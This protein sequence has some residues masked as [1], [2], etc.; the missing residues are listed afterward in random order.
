MYKLA[1]I[2]KFCTLTLI[3]FAFTALVVTAPVSAQGGLEGNHTIRLNLESDGK[4]QVVHKIELINNTT[5]VIQA[6][7]LSLPFTK[8]KD[9]KV[10]RGSE[11]IS[12]RVLPGGF[13]RV[14]L[15]NKPLFPQRKATLQFEYQLDNQL[16]NENGLL[17]FYLP[18]FRPGEKLA[19]YSAIIRYP[20]NFPA[21]SYISDP[22][23]ITD[24][25]NKL[26]FSKNTHVKL[27]WGTEWG[28]ALTGDTSDV[29][30]NDTA[31]PKLINLIPDLPGQEAIY[32]NLTAEEIYYEQNGNV[33]ANAANPF[34]FDVA[35]TRNP[36]L[37]DQNT[38]L[39]YYE[40][41]NYPIPEDIMEKTQGTG[42]K[43]EKLEIVYNY[44]VNNARV[45]FE[46]LESTDQLLNLEERVSLLSQNKFNSLEIAYIFSGYLSNLDIEH[47]IDYGYFYGVNWPEFN[48]QMPHVWVEV[49]IDGETLVYDPFLDKAT[50][51]SFAGVSD[52]GRVRFGIWDPTQT[53][54]VLLGLAGPGIRLRPEVADDVVIASSSDTQLGVHPITL[55]IEAP[56]SMN[57]I[58]QYTVTVKL[59]N[60]TTTIIPLAQIFWDDIDFSDAAL[61]LDDRLKKALP[62]LGSLELELSGV[63]LN[64]LFK[65][66]YVE[67][68]VTIVPRKLAGESN[69]AGVAS[70]GELPYSGIQ[71]QR[72]SDGYRILYVMD[73]QILVAAF[74]FILLAIVGVVVLW[75]RWETRQRLVKSFQF[76]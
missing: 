24:E 45:D 37:N 71:L 25:P 63:A 47:R 64:K 61:N 30:I 5:R 65:D 17:S 9:L 33:W 74:L 10:F 36:L 1:K 19:G 51:M 60:N 40:Y 66:G 35:I 31:T 7:D 26:T 52:V 48:E 41:V 67:H 12:Y 53:A 29:V 23:A 46:H 58:Q 38:S 69:V 8:V 15:A 28:V 50:G 27:V 73:L 42:S 14:S 16:S 72:V 2:C 57:S 44:L 20:A 18:S 54:D 55:G 32:G 49:D 39:P 62:P 76:E 11:R 13:Q 3:T 59:Q 56:Q 68:R 21:L 34:E 70:T 6:Y 22:T 4:A 75:Y 43:R